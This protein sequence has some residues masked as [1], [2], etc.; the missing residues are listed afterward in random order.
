MRDLLA[1]WRRWS[2]T[3]RILAMTLTSAVAFGIPLALALRFG[4]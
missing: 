4:G 3:E 1:D 2:P